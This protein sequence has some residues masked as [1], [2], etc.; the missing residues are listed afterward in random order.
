MSYAAIASHLQTT[1]RAVQYA[2]QAGHPTPSSQSQPEAILN[3][4]DLEAEQPRCLGSAI[5]AMPSV[6]SQYHRPAS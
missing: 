3:L 6:G 2:V 5:A 1:E 4:P